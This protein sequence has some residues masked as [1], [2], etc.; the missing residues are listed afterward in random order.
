MEQSKLISSFIA[1]L[2]IAY[3]YYFKDLTDE[4][5]IGMVNLYQENLSVYRSSTLS[6]AL[7]K[8]IRNN[9]FMP[10][11]KEII[12][13]CENCKT[14]KKNYILDKMYQTGYFKDISEYEKALKFV[15]EDIIPQWLLN[16]MKKF[17]PKQIENNKPLLN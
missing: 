4:E 5:F 15:E 13:T 8:I 17:I 2:K 12:D 10:S 1:K 9:K 6:E 3:P 7:K 11:M 16:D 14:N